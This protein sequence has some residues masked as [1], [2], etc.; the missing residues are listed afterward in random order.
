MYSLRKILLITIA[1]SSFFLP[2]QELYAGNNLLRRLCQLH[3]VRTISAS[4][5]K[6]SRLRQRE[7]WIDDHL[8]INSP[9]VAPQKRRQFMTATSLDIPEPDLA[10]MDLVWVNRI[11]TQS[12]YNQ[13]ITAFLDASHRKEVVT[14]MRTVIEESAF[15]LIDPVYR[16]QFV[17]LCE[18]LESSPSFTY[19]QLIGLTEFYRLVTK[20]ETY[21]PPLGED[22]ATTL[23]KTGE[24]FLTHFFAI[25]DILPVDLS[26]AGVKRIND[27][28]GAGVFYEYA[29]TP[30]HQNPYIIDFSL[31]INTPS[32]FFIHDKDH[33]M[34]A[35][36]SLNRF[37]E[38]R[39]QG[40][41][42]EFLFDL[43]IDRTAIRSLYRE[44]QALI[45]S[46]LPEELQQQFEELAEA[47][48]F[49]MEHEKNL[50]ISS[51]TRRS[52]LPSYNVLQ[53]PSEVRREP[54][55]T[56]ADAIIEVI[57]RDLQYPNG[58]GEIFSG[59]KPVSIDQQ[60]WLALRDL[61]DQTMP[62]ISQMQM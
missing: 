24:Q 18:F 22:L 26:L 28:W 14:Y 41:D 12:F 23:D 32:Q 44:R 9:D 10:I 45:K 7:Q 25:P 34:L 2:M 52:D 59:D 15:G 19:R 60:N 6:A 55:F 5:E 46:R 17:K 29:I 42:P 38:A 51:Q 27:R 21:V 11:A 20:R 61:L 49:T 37:A 16:E 43:H 47:T 56:F 30:P 40:L 8:K 13:Q 4:V 31:E 1:M 50:I 39:Q 53:L 35:D 62:H 36:Q 54:D 33:W 58:I 3:I 48:W 57:A